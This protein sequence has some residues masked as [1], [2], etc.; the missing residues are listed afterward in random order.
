VIN[1]K[2]SDWIAVLSGVP[3]GSVLG[4]ILFNIFIND[5]DDTVTA[6][7]LLKKFVDVVGQVLDSD[8]SALELQTALN[9]LYDWSVRWVM[10]FNVKKC[11]VLHIEKNNP[12][13]T[14]TMGGQR[15]DVS[16]SERDVDITICNTL[17]PSEQCRKAAATANTVL[18]QIHRSF[19]YRD[20]HT[21]IRLYVQDV[22][23]HLE[24]AA[25]AWSPWKKSRKGPSDR[26]LASRAGIIL[27]VLLNSNCPV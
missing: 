24:F 10:E 12:G 4:L 20:R 17:K 8:S 11:H 3:Q 18:S 26:C 1:G 6:K 21:Y 7:Q 23:P 25:P 15:L 2:F 27:A 5:L 22:R 19:H 9:N 13:H 14:Y 16:T